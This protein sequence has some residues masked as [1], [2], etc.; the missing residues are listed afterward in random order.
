[1]QPDEINKYQGQVNERKFLYF[2]QPE[3]KQLQEQVKKLI[4]ELKAQ[5]DENC[6]EKEQL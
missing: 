5:V 6:E 4:G 3:V 1:M 2:E